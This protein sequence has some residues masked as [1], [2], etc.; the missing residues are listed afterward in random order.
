MQKAVAVE[1]LRRER[2]KMAALRAKVEKDLER[3]EKYDQEAEEEEQS[4]GKP[5]VTGA[6]AEGQPVA[7]QGEPIGPQ[8]QPAGGSQSSPLRRKGKEAS[9]K[10]AGKAVDAVTP[11]T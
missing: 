2:G 10:G 7:A 11:G 9:A 8:E 5:E 1:E 3:Q 4:A 6:P